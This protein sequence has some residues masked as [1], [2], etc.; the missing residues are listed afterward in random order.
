[1]SS[2]ILIYKQAKEFEMEIKLFTKLRKD[3][4][5]WIYFHIDRL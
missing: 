2:I 3:N 1:M 4:P 5:H